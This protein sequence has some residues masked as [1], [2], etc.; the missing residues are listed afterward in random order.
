MKENDLFEI[1]GFIDN[2]KIEEAY[3]VKPKNKNFAFIKRLSFAACFILIAAIS[4]YVAN[5]KDIEKSPVKENVITE[6]EKG[7]GELVNEAPPQREKTEINS[8]NTLLADAERK[9]AE[10]EVMKQESSFD[11]DSI[12]TE[13]A[14]AEESS[15]YTSGGGGGSSGSSASRK[16]N[17]SL[18]YLNSLN[19]K[20]KE[21]ATSEE[22]SFI[23]SSCVN[24]DINRVE[25]LVTSM[26]KDLIDRINTL[27]TQGGAI[28]L[29][30]SVELQKNL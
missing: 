19:E 30:L 18:D 1:I 4:F 28:E 26:E 23:V 29:K 5:E 24:E 10:N 12:V 21:Q 17:F 11:E 16:D 8:Q 14:V 3:N 9:E 6:H 27:D 7:G 13:D 22:F 15:D 25:V 2:E 20:I